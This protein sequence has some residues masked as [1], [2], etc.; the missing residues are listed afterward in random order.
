MV[1]KKNDCPPRGRGGRMGNVQEGGKVSTEVF[2]FLFAELCILY[3]LSDIIKSL[4][5]IYKT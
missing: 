5:K 4:N 2:M 3:I 1:H